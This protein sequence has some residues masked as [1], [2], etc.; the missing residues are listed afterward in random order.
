MDNDIVRCGKCWKCGCPL[1]LPRELYE[2]AQ[3]S[4]DVGVY[5]GYGHRGV[6]TGRPSE[7]D[8]LRLERDRLKQQLAQ[9]DDSISFWR[10]NAEKNERQLRAQKGVVT[11]L[12]KR[13]S[14]G[15]C[16][17]CNRTFSALARHMKA[18]HP[19]FVCEDL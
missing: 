16:P 9:K 1:V 10:E 17:C 18:K 11:K 15:V 2:A 12:R 4:S 13:A 19:T 7:A 6:F 5:C 8:Q 3:R 14:G